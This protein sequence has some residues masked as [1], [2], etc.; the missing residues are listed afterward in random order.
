[1]GLALCS[2]EQIKSNL[3]CDRARAHPASAVFDANMLL[4][5]NASADVYY[6]DP[7]PAHW[8]RRRLRPIHA[9]APFP[10]TSHPHL[11]P[12]PTYTLSR[13]QVLLEPGA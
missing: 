13:G 8:G 12:V 2:L 3:C 7:A 11:G 6:S 5:T 1:M 9:Y 10:L 4:W